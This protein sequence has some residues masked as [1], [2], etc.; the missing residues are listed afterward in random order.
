VMDFHGGLVN[1]RLQRV[2]CIR[3]IRKGKRHNV[4]SLNCKEIKYKSKLTT[5]KDKGC[6]PGKQ[7]E[8]WLTPA[9]D[10]YL[11]NSQGLS[12]VCFLKAVLK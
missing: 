1:M 5:R 8:G 2:G 6:S 9:G 3:K 11:N 7:F 12:P 10:G 4:L